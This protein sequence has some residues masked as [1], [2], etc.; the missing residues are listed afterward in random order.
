MLRALQNQAFHH[1]TNIT[2]RVSLLHSPDWFW[3]FTLTMIRWKGGLADSSSVGTAGDLSNISPVPG[4][5][6]SLKTT[7]GCC[8]PST[9]TGGRPGSGVAGLELPPS[10]LLSPRPDPVWP[11]S[12]TPWEMSSREGF[13]RV[14][15]KGGSCRG[16][17]TSS[18]TGTE[19]GSLKSCMLTS[20]TGVG[21]GDTAV[22]SV[23]VWGEC[24]TGLAVLA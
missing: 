7:A 10:P 21:V 8:P 5:T 23:S 17:K 16:A 4:V 6:S 22:G 2:C 11:P 19:L 3:S 9:P 14:V 15:G 24:G 1:R 12:S 20:S 18:L 13:E